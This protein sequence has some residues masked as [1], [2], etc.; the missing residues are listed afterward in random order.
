DRAEPPEPPARCPA[1]DTPTVKPED[2]VWTICPNRA[3][4]PG[5]VLQ[6]VKHFVGAMDIDG[7]GEETAIRFL[8]EGVIKDAADIYELD[9]DRLVQLEGVA[10]ISLNNLRPNGEASKHQ[11]LY[12]VRYSAGIP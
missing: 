11:P 12:R 5:Q 4:C 10:E 6:H 3:G 1:C 8:R 7:F 2:G 9:K